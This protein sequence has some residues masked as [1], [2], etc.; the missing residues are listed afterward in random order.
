M[1][2]QRPQPGIA[3]D[4]RGGAVI[5]PTKNVLD[6]V[7]GSIRRIDDM[8]QLRVELVNE[9]IVRL[10]ALVLSSEK[11][12]SLRAV[13]QEA[14]D[15][16]ESKRLD[17]TRQYDQLAVQTA[18]SR[19]DAAITALATTAATTAETLRNAVNTSAINLA[20]QLD[21]TV[22]A[23][24]ERIA[25]LE[26]SSYV[27]AG[28]QAVVDPQMERL[29]GVV[30]KLANSTSQSHGKTEG[31]GASWSVLVGI[32]AILISGFALFNRAAPAA[33]V[34]Q[35]QVIYVPAPQGTMVPSSPSGTPR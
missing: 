19:S 21:R 31:I 26:K 6:L 16:L 5:D 22:T 34:A 33:P 11:I 9:K 8:A 32:L 24:T 15:A 4:G 12:V 18:A 29:A 30:E 7:D 25:A 10:E 17:S 28:K 20:T 3:V 35:P 14:M 23:I 13:H 2:K 27:G 1:E